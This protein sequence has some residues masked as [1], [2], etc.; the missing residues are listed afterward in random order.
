MLFLCNTLC[1]P[2]LPFQGTLRCSEMLMGSVCVCLMQ[3]W[4]ELGL[5]AAQLYLGYMYTVSLNMIPGFIKTMGYRMVR[6]FTQGHTA[7]NAHVGYNYVIL[8][9]MKVDFRNTRRPLLL[10]NVPA[11][12]T[13]KYDS[14]VQCHFFI[15][16]K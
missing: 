14:L 8:P 10:L 5:K 13:I 1:K 15:C 3:Q 4:A 6:S 2:V 9:Q 11:V 16:E 7:Y 12:A